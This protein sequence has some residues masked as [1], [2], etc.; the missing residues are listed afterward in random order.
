MKATVELTEK[1]EL[2]YN[3]CIKLAQE[4]GDSGYEFAFFVL[5]DRMK[6]FSTNQLKGFMSSLTKKELL[7]END[8]YFDFNVVELY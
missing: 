8:G 5:C 7:E 1:E 6:Q 2:V 4:E 3:E